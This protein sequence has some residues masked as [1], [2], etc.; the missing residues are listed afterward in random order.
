MLFTAKA[1]LV[2]KFF[3]VDQKRSTKNC[4]LHAPTGNQIHT[5]A[6]T[7][8]QNINVQI[9]IVTMVKQRTK[10]MIA[11]QKNPRIIRHILVLFVIYHGLMSA[12]MIQEVAKTVR[13]IMCQQIQQRNIL[14]RR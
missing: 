7:V 10:M 14:I 9:L 6:R 2:L 13:R 8:S 5:G 1:I 3:V 4:I 11:K 12:A